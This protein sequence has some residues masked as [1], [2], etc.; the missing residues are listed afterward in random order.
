MHFI[1]FDAPS[2]VGT[3]LLH[4]LIITALVAA[5]GAL[6][7][8]GG[9]GAAFVVARY[10]S[11]GSD[12]VSKRRVA[13][14]SL[15]AIVLIAVTF[16]L[17]LKFFD[18]FDEADQIEARYDEPRSEQRDAWADQIDDTYGI[19]VSHGQIADLNPPDVEPTA[20]GT[21]GSTEIWYD[22]QLTDLTLTWTGD[23]FVLTGE[24]GEALPTR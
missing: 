19:S 4:I 1:P 18:L 17:T 15:V 11:W 24:D 5:G 20:P 16:A 23:E 21:Y 2:G 9:L 3:D 14:V 22:E 6:S 7:L 8:G 12:E 13:F 10:L